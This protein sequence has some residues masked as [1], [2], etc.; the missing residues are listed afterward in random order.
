[1]L[2]TNARKKCCSKAILFE[3]QDYEIKRFYSIDIGFNKDVNENVSIFYN[4]TASALKFDY[5]NQ[6]MSFSVITD[7]F[8]LHRARTLALELSVVISF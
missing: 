2:R 6:W 1:M 7:D 4:V 3:F 5:Q 8:Q